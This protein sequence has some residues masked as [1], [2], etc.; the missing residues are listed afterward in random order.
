MP[1][2]TQPIQTT[3]LSQTNLNHLYSTTSILQT[4][5]TTYSTITEH[6]QSLKSIELKQPTLSINFE[7]ENLVIGLFE[8]KS[9]LYD[10]ELFAM[11]ETIKELMITKFK[12]PEELFNE[13]YIKNKNKI[14]NYCIDK[15]EA[16]KVARK[17]TNS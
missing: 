10:Y 16:N 6:L 7:D 14:E 12:I 1:Q 15:I 3:Q 4:K 5:P 13:T 9:S 2:V 8:I 11:L 17:L